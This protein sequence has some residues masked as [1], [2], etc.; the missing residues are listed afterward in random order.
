MALLEREADGATPVRPAQAPRRR[1]RSRRRRN[2][3]V[4]IAVVIIA[5]LVLVA[6][7]APWIAPYDPL[8]A[9]GANKY[10]P[11]G[12]DGHLLGT[13]DQGRDIL[14]RLIWGGR[15]SLLVAF[16]ASFAATVIGSA[17]ALVAGFSGDKMAGLIMRTIDVMFAFPVII[18][19]V[20]FALVFDPG[21][22]VVILSII[23]AAVP[24]VTRVVFT[25]V[26]QQRG[27]EYIEAAES[28]GAGLPS[29]LFRE[30]LPNVVSQIVVYGT[31]LV[32][33]MIVFSSSL[34]ALGIGVQP[35]T[36]DWGR[37]ISEGAKVIISGNIYVALLPGLAVLL[38]ALAFNWLGDGLRDVFDPHQRKARP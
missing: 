17:L 34:S 21:A 29:I 14:S 36:A 2:T 26:K 25:E 10:L 13:D 11:L 6:L 1:P 31:G 37:M 18:I 23:F 19:A 16:I 28:L 32:G 7:L 3:Q 24:Y 4:T 38:V 27:R 35:P 8:Q 20:V 22:F 9:D 12:S 30:V 33:G 15:T 5:V